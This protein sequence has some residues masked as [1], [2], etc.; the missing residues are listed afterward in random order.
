MQAR[1]GEEEYALGQ[2]FE[3]SSPDENA[4]MLKAEFENLVQGETFRKGFEELA[5]EYNTSLPCK[6]I[7]F[8]VGSSTHL[9]DALEQHF[10]SIWIMPFLVGLVM[11]TTHLLLWDY[12][13]L[14]SLQLAS[15]PVVL[16]MLQ[17]RNS[18][19]MMMLAILQSREN[20]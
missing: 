19:G 8:D 11:T 12:L 20:T 3:G 5:K 9:S 18:R 7:P 4:A 1:F 13:I 15:S 2:G 6:P 10:V 14:T 17:S 16:L